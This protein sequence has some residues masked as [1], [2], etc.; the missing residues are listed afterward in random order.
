M[1][2][3]GWTLEGQ[4]KPSIKLSLITGP[5]IEYDPNV[6]TKVTFD[7]GD[8]YMC[9]MVGALP[10][11]TRS[12][13]C[14]A[15]LKKDESSSGEAERKEERCCKEHNSFLFSLLFRPFLLGAKNPENA[16]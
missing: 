11:C 14:S 16:P 7:D 9:D 12:V 5:C 10:H 15:S 13:Q 3:K 8:C 4:T 1:W 6:R 2:G